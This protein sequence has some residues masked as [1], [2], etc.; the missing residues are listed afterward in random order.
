MKDIALPLSQLESTHQIPSQ[1]KKGSNS[2]SYYPPI[3][4]DNKVS[5]VESIRSSQSTDWFSL[6]MRSASNTTTNGFSVSV[7][8]EK[9]A[10]GTLIS[11]IQASNGDAE[12]DQSQGTGQEAANHWGKSSN[13]KLAIDLMG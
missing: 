10:H 9:S 7:A 5:F 4:K 11:F 12:G 1:S 13:E 6:S 8:S 2:T 3:I